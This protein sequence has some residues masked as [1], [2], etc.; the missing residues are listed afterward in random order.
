[1]VGGGWRER[2]AWEAAKQPIIR[3]KVKIWGG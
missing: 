1:M 3:V 2:L